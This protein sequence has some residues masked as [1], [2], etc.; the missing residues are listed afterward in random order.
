MSSDAYLKRLEQRAK[1][2]RRTLIR[3][4]SVEVDWR[5][6]RVTPAEAMEAVS[7]ALEAGIQ[8]LEEGARLTTPTS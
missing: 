5:Q 2:Y 4:A 6:G 1:D 7:K 3:I 8:D